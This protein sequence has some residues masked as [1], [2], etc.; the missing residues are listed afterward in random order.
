MGEGGLTNQLTKVSVKPESSVSVKAPHP[1]SVLVRVYGDGTESF[2]D[3]ENEHRIFKQFSDEGIG[4]KLY[5]LFDGGR[6]EQ[7]LDATS[8]TCAVLFTPSC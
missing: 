5:G 4:P 3:R 8:L 6:V 7:F 1:Q 2:F